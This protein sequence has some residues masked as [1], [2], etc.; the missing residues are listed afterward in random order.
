MDLD[1]GLEL[2][3]LEKKVNVDLINKIEACEEHE[4]KSLLEECE[5]RHSN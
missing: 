5:R 2:D 3:D 1:E 4:K